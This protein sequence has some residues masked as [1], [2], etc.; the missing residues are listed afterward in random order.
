MQSIRKKGVSV[1]RLQAG[2][3]KAKRGG[4]NRTYASEVK[5]CYGARS[6]TPAGDEGGRAREGRMNN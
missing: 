2:N 5:Q 3:Q 1:V 4:G 6:D